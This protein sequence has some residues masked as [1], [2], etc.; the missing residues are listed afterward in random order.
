M[1]P[2]NTPEVTPED[3]HFPPEDGPPKS[4]ARAHALYYVKGTKLR[5][6]GVT[7]PEVTPEGSGSAPLPPNF[8]GS[9]FGSGGRCGEQ[10]AAVRDKMLGDLHRLGVRGALEHWTATGFLGPATLQVLTDRDID[11]MQRAVDAP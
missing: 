6:S 4:R 9:G 8:G 11:A 1:T 7:P 10:F 2:G 3:G 5:G